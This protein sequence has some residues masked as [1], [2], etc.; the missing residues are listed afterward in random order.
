MVVWSLTFWLK[1]EVV[2]FR[3]IYI[4]IKTRENTPLW[5]AAEATETASETA[6]EGMKD[7][8]VMAPDETEDARMTLACSPWLLCIGTGTISAVTGMEPAIRYDF[9]RNC[10]EKQKII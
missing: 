10:I 6:T 4:R 7:D 9:L 5:A 2:S 8:D 3:Q 1:Y